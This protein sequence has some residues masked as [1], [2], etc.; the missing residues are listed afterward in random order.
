MAG[1]Y[2]LALTLFLS[3]LTVANAFNNTCY[4]PDFDWILRPSHKTFRIEFH[5]KMYGEHPGLRP[6]TPLLSSKKVYDEPAEIGVI[7]NLTLNY[8]YD[9][10]KI[11]FYLISESSFRQ[12]FGRNHSAFNSTGRDVMCVNG[13]YDFESGQ[14]TGFLH[15]QPMRD[16]DD[17]FNMTLRKWLQ[18]PAY[19]FVNGTDVPNGNGTKTNETDNKPNK[20]IKMASEYTLVMFV[21]LLTYFFMLVQ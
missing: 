11:H 13:L 7:Y 4:F 9:D 10:F 21:I 1:G 17:Y 15:Y 19:V 8:P 6:N 12:A 18:L 5:E 20:G 2:W 16:K 3:C 14:P